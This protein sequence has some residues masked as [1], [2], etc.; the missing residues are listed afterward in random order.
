MSQENVQVVPFSGVGSGVR[1]TPSSDQ[2]VPVVLDGAA[3]VTVSRLL[4]GS[5]ITTGAPG[6]A[7]FGTVS[8]RLLALSPTASPAAV[9]VPTWRTSGE[10]PLATHFTSTVMRLRSAGCESSL[11]SFSPGSLQKVLSCAPE[12]SL[13]SS[14][15]H[16]L[17]VTV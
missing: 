3:N 5:V 16:S 2:A 17:T 15:E 8:C 6:A 7:T 10:R 11:P 14:I 9:S 4:T 12:P 13:G 1:L